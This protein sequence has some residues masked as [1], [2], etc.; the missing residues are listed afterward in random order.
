MKLLK[1]T[2]FFTLSLSLRTATHAEETHVSF[3]S[4]L[5]VHKTPIDQ[6]DPEDKF[7]L[8]TYFDFVNLNNISGPANM[9]DESCTHQ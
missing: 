7:D 8:L 3:I 9:S 5:Q 4:F 1:I 6:L 2:F